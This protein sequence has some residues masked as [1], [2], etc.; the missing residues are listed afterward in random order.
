MKYY[1]YK[2]TYKNKLYTPKIKYTNSIFYLHDMQNII[3]NVIYK[4]ICQI[5][6]CTR[7]KIYKQFNFLRV[8]ITC[9]TSLIIFGYP[10]FIPVFSQETITEAEELN[11]Y[12]YEKE[13]EAE[14]EAFYY[15]YLDDQSVIT[16][17]KKEQKASQ[18]PAI[19]M[20]ITAQQIKERGYSTIGEALESVAGIDLIHDGLQYNLG[21]RGIN[22]GMR[23]GSRIVK[24]MIDGQPVSYRPSSENLLGEELIPISVVEK[25]EVIRGPGSALYGANAFLG[26]INI[27]TKKSQNFQPGYTP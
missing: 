3:Y 22:G 18:A 16:A 8:V 14:E 6:Y 5:Y 11:F 2:H 7:M 15:F 17:T 13:L 27:I 21:I 1:N 25:I 4:L 24:L 19:I 9:I 12:Q 20:V 26:V 10:A 23:A